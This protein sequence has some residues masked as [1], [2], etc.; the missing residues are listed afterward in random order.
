MRFSIVSSRLISA[1]ETPAVGRR[2]S[3]NMPDGSILEGDHIRAVDD[4]RVLLA[5]GDVG[6]DVGRRDQCHA[7]AAEPR[8]QMK[9]IFASTRS[10]RSLTF[11][12][13]R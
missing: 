11:R 2:R 3:G 9:V 10:S 7:P 8:L 5:L 6:A 4:L 1:F 13:L 12:L